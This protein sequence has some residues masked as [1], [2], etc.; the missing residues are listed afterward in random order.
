MIEI[1]NNA[2]YIIEQLEA[3]GFEAYAVGGCVRDSVLGRNPKDWDITTSARPAEVKNIFRRTIDTG[4]QHGTVTVMI[5]KEGYEV[6]TYRIDGEYED[7]RHPKEVIYT[8]NLVED[9]KRRDFTINAMAYNPGLGMVD[10]FG[11][12]EDINNKVIRCVGNPAH[13]FEED[14]LRMLRA[15][16]FSAELDFTVEEETQAA[17]VR[18][19]PSLSKISAERI[20]TELDK[21]LCSGHPERLI[22]AY[23]TGITRIVLPELDAM[24]ATE[25]NNPHHCYSVG[26]H[27]IRA[28][29]EMNR[30]CHAHEEWGEKIHSILVWTMLLHDSAKPGRK[31][32]D[33]QGIDHFHGHPS[34]SAVL[35]ETILRRLRFDNYTVDTVKRLVYWH[36]YRFGTGMAAMRRAVNKIGDDIFDYLLAVETAD[37]SA[38]SDYLR[39][40][41][42]GRIE[43]AGS[44]AARIRE[45][46]QPVSLRDLKLNGG[47]LIAM[48]IPAGRRIGE[49]LGML[50]EAVLEDPEL[51]DKG[52][53]KKLAETW[54]E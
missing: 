24:M 12:M 54:N 21:L 44:L 42:L 8:A 52:T 53:L 10:A 3:H 26:G 13:R 5:D 27:T 49:I 45:Q 39:D 32:T 38:Q 41:K 34:E 51:N 16:R 7:S 18:Q 37:V 46:E 47:D 33:E 23:E 31:T 50:L 1:P 19:A 48:G 28:I 40:E 14:A 29:Q 35:A 36:D 9:L 4:I 25:Q 15:V 11:G 20:R 30:L 2:A 6:T 43:L 22:L 17:I